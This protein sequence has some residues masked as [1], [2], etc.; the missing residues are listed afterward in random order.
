MKAI[1][2]GMVVMVLVFISSMSLAQNQEQK[3]QNQIEP[4]KVNEVVQSKKTQ[5]FYALNKFRG[6]KSKKKNR[7][8]RGESLF[9]Y[10][11]N[12]SK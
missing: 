7:K 6:L 8:R 1:G 11:P 12:C 2:K 10:I 3:E 4:V 9:F 5:S